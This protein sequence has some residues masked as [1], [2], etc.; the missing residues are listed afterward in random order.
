MK[1]PQNPDALRTALQPAPTDMDA[2]D[3][4]FALEPELIV[5]TFR[6][7][8][9][10]VSVNPA[11]ESV[12]GSSD[13][14]WSRLPEPDQQQLAG[15]LEIAAK[16]TLITNRLFLVRHPTREQPLPVLLHFLPVALPSEAG[17]PQVEAIVVTGEVLAEPTSWMLSQTERHRMETLGRM[18]MGIV[19]DFNNLLSGILGH[20]ELLKRSV[21][22]TTAKDAA[23][24]H[25]AT[26]EQASLDGAALVRKIQQYI[27]QERQ[28]D[29]ELVDLRRIIEDSVALTKPYWYNEPR[30]QGIQIDASM[31]FSEIPM[32]MGAPAELRDVFVNLILNAVQ[33][34]PQGGQISISVGT[35]EHGRAVAVVK[36]N[37]TGMTDRVRARIF[38]P[39]FSTKGKRGTGMGLAVCYGTV[40]E[41]E[42]EIEVETELGYGTTFR[43]SFPPA[44][45]VSEEAHEEQEE[46]AVRSA[47]VL[48]VDD[49]PMVRNVAARL[50]SLKG[51]EVVEAGSGR[52]A[53]Q[54][55]G[56][57]VFDVIFTDQGMPEMSGRELAA[58]L[59]ENLPHTPIV[60][61][62]G[63]TEAG[64][65]DAS[66]DLVLTK[67]FKLDELE[68]AIQNLTGVH[69]TPLQ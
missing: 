37:G 46:P 6:S 16:G 64:E 58:R 21:S 50:M 3:A 35:E 5:A 20:S 8:K 4:S 17:G 38:E 14:A 31:S 2:V 10:R 41:H 61:L 11:W 48:V 29:F 12:F 59:R 42:G 53:L 39:L 33:A 30:T 47:R 60:L 69:D 34:M 54:L 28:R 45:D 32:I 55:A 52:E 1:A 23:L 18:T 68:S 27:R 43:M 22:T 26:I 44:S 67:P 19:H 57:Q 13:D 40:Q 36:D 62:T 9:D 15:Y 63:D 65:A 25:V 7:P 66:V 56:T 51:H 24:E 49:E